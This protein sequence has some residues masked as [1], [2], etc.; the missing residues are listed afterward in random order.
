MEKKVSINDSNSN[1]IQ[2][3]NKL[4]DS[5]ILKTYKNALPYVIKILFI[6]NP[7]A[8]LLVMLSKAGARL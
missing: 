7:T 2:Q 1:K 4:G 5:K 8:W 3:G 6:P